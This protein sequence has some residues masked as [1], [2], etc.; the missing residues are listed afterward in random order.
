MSMNIMRTLT[1]NGAKFNVTPVVPA[2]S[3]TL[4]A[5]SWVGG[6]E[7]Y[8][9]VVEL[10]GITAHT[11]VDLQPTAEQLA[12]FHYKVLSFV[13][14]NDGGVVTVYAIG[15]K[16]RGDHTIQTTL[17]E[18][19]TIG[20]IRGNTVGTTMPRPDVNQTDPNSADYIRGRETLVRSVNGSTPDENGNVTVKG[21]GT[22][23][24]TDEQIATAVEAYM[25][26]HPVE[27]D[28]VK[29]VNGTPP[30]ENGNVEVAGGNS[31]IIYVTIDWDTMKASMTSHEIMEAVTNGKTV[32][33]K[34][35]GYL[36]VF[37]M[38]IEES[39]EDTVVHAYCALPFAYMTDGVTKNL[40]FDIITIDKTGSVAIGPNE[41]IVCV[42][43][44]GT[45]WDVGKVLS[46]TGAGVMEWV[47]PSTLT[48]VGV[49]VDEVTGA[50]YK[51]KVR[52]GKL[53]M[54]GV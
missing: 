21:G 52:N 23:G 36:S 24:A 44:A 5:G 34:E 25:E 51:L 14:E 17:T 45:I 13:A 12:E 35:F 8:S 41:Q 46:V 11:K 9:Q 39:H 10:P 50:S 1:I 16:P 19:D 48:G 27:C 26:E 2:S 53:M 32:M 33:Y 40:G 22:G 18:V 3:V 28:G 7:S 42:P 54:E 20:K 49:L 31:D 37:T 4:L 43:Y 15:D 6:G 47:D 30:D 38:D 29:T